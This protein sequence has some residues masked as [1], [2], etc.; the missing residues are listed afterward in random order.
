VRSL[1]NDF[2][3]DTFIGE[4]AECPSAPSFGRSRTS[5]A[6]QMGFGT[7]IEDGLG[8]RCAS[9][10]S[11]EC[12]CETFFDESFSNVGDGI[13]VAVKLFGDIL[14]GRSTVFCFID[15]EQDIGVFDFS[16]VAFAGGNEFGKFGSF[17]GGEGYFVNLLHLN[18]RVRGKRKN[19]ESK[20]QRQEQYPQF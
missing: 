18:F 19:N 9:F 3:F 10:L 4:E 16:G 6:D 15:G 17:F 14:I 8:R 20:N 11:F 2:E 7:T 5:D 12:G 1:L 13:G